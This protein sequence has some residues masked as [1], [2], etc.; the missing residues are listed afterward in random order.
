MASPARSSASSSG[1]ESVL[2]PPQPA[3]LAMVQTVNIRSHGPILLDLQ[4]P[5]YSQWRCFFDSILGKFGL[6]DLVKSPTPIA[7][8][9]AEWRQ[10]D[11]S[12][13]NWLYTTVNK[14]VF[15]IIW[16]MNYPFLMH[17]RCHLSH[18]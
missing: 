3:S 6:D 4:D 15:D 2:D 12:I 8:R 17:F 5:N 10:I 9:T 11:C 18:I 1:D 13:V 14:N 16:I 7:Q